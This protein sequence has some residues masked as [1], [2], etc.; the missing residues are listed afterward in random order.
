[1]FIKGVVT[2]APGVTYEKPILAN[3]KYA[4]VSLNFTVY[5][6]DPYDAPTVFKNGSFRGLVSTM[7]KG[8]GFTADT[9]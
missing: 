8:M 5:E 9:E 4:R 7:K 3:D 6:I 1:V 2:A